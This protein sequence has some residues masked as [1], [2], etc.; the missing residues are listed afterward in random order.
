MAGPE[1]IFPDE[2]VPNEQASSAHKKWEQANPNGDAPK[3]RTFRDKVLAYKAGDPAVSIP[4]MVTPHGK[5]LVAAGKEHMSV[6]DL[7]AVYE[8]PP[9]PPPP[10]PPPPPPGG[11]ALDTLTDLNFVF[12]PEHIMPAQFGNSTFDSN[13]GFYSLTTPYG[14]GFR[15]VVT[16][17][18]PTIWNSSAKCVLAQGQQSTFWGQENTTELW[19]WYMKF[20]GPSQQWP[21]LF[22]NDFAGVLW[23]MHRA[24]S[25]S[26]HHICL[27]SDGTWIV[28]RH[29]SAGDT[30]EE[31]ETGIPVRYDV[32]MPIQ[33][34]IKWSYTSTGFFRVNIDG[35]QIFNYSGPTD[36]S[37]AGDR[38]LQFG[39]YSW[40]QYT[41][42]VHYGGITLTR[43]T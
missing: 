25:P 24:G 12:R 34:D 33:F 43:T 35:N 19:R 36:F 16:A 26:G 14:A 37:G 20:P 31:R 41:N 2:Y 5:A 18:M 21:S 10:D 27:R 40:K 28:R 32:W 7:G 29:T 23:E 38:R 13:G 9:E 3:W 30:Y 42:E 8:P 22:S 4:A 11:I 17:N 6:I 1:R 39:F 15:M